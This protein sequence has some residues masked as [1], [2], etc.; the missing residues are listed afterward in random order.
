MQWDTWEVCPGL[1]WWPVFANSIRMHWLPLLSIDSSGSFPSGVWPNLASN[2]MG[3]PVI[4]K[5]MPTIEELPPYG[6]PVWDPRVKR[7]R[8]NEIASNKAP[9]CTF[10]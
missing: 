8:A 1:C 5:Q 10:I 9:N 3:L 6:F 2:A 7:N 4:L